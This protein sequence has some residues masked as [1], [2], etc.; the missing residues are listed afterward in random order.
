MAFLCFAIAFFISFSEN[1]TKTIIFTSYV[2][3]DKSS[4]PDEQSYKQTISPATQFKTDGVVEETNMSIE[5]AYTESSTGDLESRFIFRKELMQKACVKN[6]RQL[7]YPRCERNNAG[8]NLKYVN[9]S[10]LLYCAIEKTGST[11]WKRI[12]H[13]IGGWGND[14][15][16]TAIKSE[17]ADTVDGGFETLKNT[18]VKERREL[19]E[20]STSIMFVRDPY[21]RLFSAWLDKLYSPNHYYWT[22][23]GPQVV[24]RLRVNSDEWE[25]NPVSCASD[26]SFNEFINYTLREI[27]SYSCVDGHFS[28]NYNHCL[29]CLLSHDYVGKYETFKEDTRYLLDKLNL[30][31]KVTFDDFERDGAW[32]AIRDSTEFL[33]SQKEKILECNVT[34]FCALF[35]VWNRLQSR[36]ILSKNI[37]FPFENADDVNNVTKA[38]VIRILSYA[39]HQSDRS[40]TK[41]NRMEALQQA[42]QNLSLKLRERLVR[43]FKIDFD[44]FGYDKYPEYLNQTRQSTFKYFKEC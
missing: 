19:F 25:S 17:A 36:G 21:T 33:F 38:D 39:N 28:P 22:S 27:S 32:D 35:K 29:P 24:K 3:Q 2:K 1:R 9:S 8:L 14:S 41:G 10:S 5:G 6:K 44:M 13:V 43:T 23:L 11:L 26:I 42:Y 7:R 31:Q 20:N 18:T 16:P 30:S 37:D 12:L 4:R 15:N 34:F 40:E